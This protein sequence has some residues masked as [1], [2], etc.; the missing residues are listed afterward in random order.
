MTCNYYLDK[1][2]HSQESPDKN[3]FR[4]LSQ[5]SNKQLFSWKCSRNTK[6]WISSTGETSKKSCPRLKGVP[7]KLRRWSLTSQH[8]TQGGA[9][10]MKLGLNEVMRVEPQ[11]GTRALIGEGRDSRSRSKCTYGRKAMWG[12][13]KKMVVTQRTLRGMQSPIICLF[14][15]FDWG[16]SPSSTVGNKLLGYKPHSNP[17]YS[18]LR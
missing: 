9:F 15:S 10:E 11:D 13:S 16:L 14:R 17:V 7:L 8:D 12:Q 4:H 18:A 1:Y 2:W 3:H 6:A 5:D